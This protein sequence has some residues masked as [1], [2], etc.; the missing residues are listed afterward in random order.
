MAE[1]EAAAVKIGR[2][3]REIL[4]HLSLN[5]RASLSELAK[6]TGLSKEVVHYRIK[7]MEKEGVIEGYYAVINIYRLGKV[8]YRV[9]MKTINMTTAVEKRFISYLKHHPK[10]TWIVEVDGDLDFLYV[11]WGDTI[12]D[13]EEAYAEINDA[14]GKYVQQKFF[15]VMTSVYYFKDKYLVGKEDGTF[16]LTGG[17]IEQ[18]KVDQ[19]DKKLITL[20]SNQGR[21]QL[22]EIARQ[23]NTT[24][25]VVQHRMKK[26][27][28]ASVITCYNVKINHK[29]LGYTQRKVMLNLNDTS[30]EAMR[31]LT[32]FITYHPLTIYIT[33]AVG[34]YDFEFEM[35]EQ[36]HE[37]FH[38]IMKELKNRFPGLIKN[39]FTVIFYNEPRVGQLHMLRA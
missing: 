37:D 16:R 4:F 28:R 38:N 3:D 14:F 24:A 23:L 31:K 13:F 21:L 32:S 8:F 33:I 29:A 5:A 6:R 1:T 9:Y 17:R 36:S 19:L 25:K 18:P 11:V 20:L 35:M 2:K 12:N 15:S 27:I 26:L 30:K 7:K 34:Q 22:V 10:V 39:Y